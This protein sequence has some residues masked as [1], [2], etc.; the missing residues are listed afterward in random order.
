MKFTQFNLDVYGD[1]LIVY[2]GPDTNSPLVGRFTATKIPAELVHL[3]AN[4]PSGA[5]T[6]RFVSDIMVT[7]T[8]W[9]ATV[10]ETVMHPNDLE[11]A[12][13]AGANRTAVGTDETYTLSIN[14][15]GR[16]EVS[17]NDYCVK[18]VNQDGNVLATAQGVDIPF[19]GSGEVELHY[20][21][22]A[23]GQMSLKAVVDFARD[24]N[25]DNNTSANE[26]ASTVYPA[27]TKYVQIVTHGTGVYVCPASFYSSE[28]VWETVFD[29]S[30]IGVEAGKLT[31]MSFPV[32]STKN[33]TSIPVTIYVGETAK[34][35]LDEHSIY[36]S[37]LNKV[38]EGNVPLRTTTTEWTFS[39]DT[40]YDYKG[41][42]LVVL[43]HKVAPGTDGQ[44]VVFG[45]SYEK[46]EFD[47][48][49]TRVAST[50]Y[51]DE[52][53]DLESDYGWPSAALPDINLLFTRES[54]GISAVAASDVRIIVAANEV[55]VDGAQGSPVTVYT[56][57]G[58]IVAHV[59]RA[60]AVE[61]ITLNAPGLYVIKAGTAVAKVKTVN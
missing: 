1:T 38:F 41:G 45:G 30:M 32:E 24:D 33:Y 57:D 44:G 28:S 43:M 31:L 5:L 55:T 47:P 21:A 54:S 17:G 50:Y 26:I 25:Q 19:L 53:L 27:G 3:R 56:V 9:L 58:R 10:T 35:N 46:S 13:L 11:A 2:D 61:H 51:P 23:E 42:N 14:N 29:K 49:R 40:P 7:S 22:K 16:N 8:G 60:Q 39:L 12:T 37:E 4:N 6:F 15:M 48:N 18:L 34:D 36:A 52:H 59:P 20:A